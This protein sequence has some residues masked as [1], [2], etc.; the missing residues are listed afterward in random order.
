MILIDIYIKPRK[1]VDF[2]SNTEVYIKDIADVYTHKKIIPII[3]GKK[4]MNIN[5]DKKDKSYLISIIDIIKVIKSMFPE[6]YVVNLG[7][8]DII[9]DYYVKDK[10]ANKPKVILKVVFIS[11]ILFAGSCTAIMSFHSD[12]EL[13]KIFNSYYESFF[14]KDI[15]SNYALISVPYSLGILAGI[16]GFFN[17]FV[18]KKITNDPTPIEVEITS[19]EDE[20]IKR[21]IETLDKKI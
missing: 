4:L 14:G 16:L 9:V 15:K 17:H 20:V 3:N 5:N 12:S 19:Y 1:K 8:S 7:E 18:G 13:P 21:K 10:Y 6:A 11:I 2:I